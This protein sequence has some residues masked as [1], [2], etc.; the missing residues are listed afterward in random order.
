MNVPM[1]P[2]KIAST[3][4]ETP[5][6]KV[7]VK[8]PRGE[9]VR[10]FAVLHP[11]FRGDYDERMAL[12]TAPERDRVDFATYARKYIGDLDKQL[13]EQFGVGFI[14]HGGFLEATPLFG[15]FDYVL[16]SLD[17]GPVSQVASMLY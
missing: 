5:V 6:M 7:V 14:P 4:V 12:L 10:T 16:I 15:D 17:R 1:I 11:A 3:T 8:S 13:Q 9:V 2:R